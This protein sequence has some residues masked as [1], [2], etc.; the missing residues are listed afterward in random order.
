MKIGIFGGS[1][2][3]IHVGHTKLA[4]HLIDNNIVDRV[5]LMPTPCSPFKV[6]NDSIIDAYHRYKMTKIACR[7]LYDA[8]I[9]VSNYEMV[10]FADKDCVYTVDTLKKLVYE[11]IDSDNTY[12]F[13]VGADTFNDIKK[14]KNHQWI[15]N[16][17]IIKLIVFGRPGYEIDN[18]INTKN[19]IFVNDIALIDISSSEI[20]DNVCD[21]GNPDNMGNVSKY[22]DTDV[23]KYILQN[24]LYN[25]EQ[26]N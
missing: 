6:Y 5:L 24:N 11:N 19:C 17:G 3:P 10:N 25:H 4:K 9:T 2:N 15:L 23:F 14:F 7:N 13:I 1:F 18:S 16:S 8:R 22:L 12:Y 21:Y 20:R 26:D